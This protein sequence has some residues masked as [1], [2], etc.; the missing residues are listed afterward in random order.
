VRPSVPAQGVVNAASY[1]GGGVAP[2]ELVTLFGTALGPAST[3]FPTV[4]SL[5]FV[6]T[7]AGGARVLFDGV[8][9]PMVS[10][11]AGQVSAVVPFAVSGRTITQVQV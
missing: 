5:G 11:V 3:Q 2:G 8:A 10:A 7:I 4:N 6:D 1:Q 9:A